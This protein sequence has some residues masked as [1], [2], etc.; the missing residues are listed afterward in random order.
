MCYISICLRHSQ[1][2]DG[3]SNIIGMPSLYSDNDVSSELSDSTHPMSQP[4]LDYVLGAALEHFR[5]FGP[6]I[7]SVL[8]DMKVLEQDIEQ[9]SRVWDTQYCRRRAYLTPRWPMSTH[10]LTLYILVAFAPDSLLRAYLPRPALKPK[11]G[12]NPLIYAAHCDKHEQAQTLLS[13]GAK[14]NCR[15]WELNDSLQALPIEVA[16]RNH[17]YSMVALFVAEGSIVSP[18]IFTS[19]FSRHYGMIP[20]SIK[21][22]L[23]QTDDFAEAVDDS[24]NDLKWEF[25]NHHRLFD[26]SMGTGKDLVHLVRRMIQVSQTLSEVTHVVMKHLGCARAHFNPAI[27]RLH[28][29]YRDGILS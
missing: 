25:W 18:Q 1:G 11:K 20:S 13:R 5:H 21:R 15:G 2:S 9:Y 22:I 28:S 26:A 3:P 8:Y 19:L 6:R 14:L 17:H 4:L 27:F 24:K 12:T 10:D 16:L 7:G 29:Q 23:L